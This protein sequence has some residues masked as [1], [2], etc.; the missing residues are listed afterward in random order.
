M[1]KHNDRQASYMVIQDQSS[2]VNLG[3]LITCILI[4]R[5]SHFKPFKIIFKKCICI[6]MFYKVIGMN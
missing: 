6:H 5:E 3:V 2:N 4:S 1:K